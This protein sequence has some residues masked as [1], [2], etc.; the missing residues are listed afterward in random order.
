MERKRKGVGDGRRS[1]GDADRRVRADA[2]RNIDA[3]LDAAKAAFLKSGVDAPVRAI[4]DRA[5]VGIG[6]L[7]RHFPTRADLIA[8]V[9]R[10]EVDACAA[11]A[12][13]LA[14][15][16][17]P[18]EALRRWVERYVDFVRTKRGLAAALHSGDPAYGALPDY[19]MHRLRP[20]L[21]GLLQAA[22]AAGSVRGGVDAEDLLW[23]IASLC[24]SRRDADPLIVQRM[25]GLLL[26]GLRYGV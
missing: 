2:Q 25:I 15:E 16:H 20:A 21:D 14:G 1:P 23:A 24:A 3:L 11:A 22:V 4:A 6:T 9:F 17:G 19:F 18:A 12:P 7:Y 26:D 5:G 8:A 10:H 13:N